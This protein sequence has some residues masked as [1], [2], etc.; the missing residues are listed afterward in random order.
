M[1]KE[2]TSKEV[3]L[4]YSENETEISKIWISLGYSASMKDAVN[5]RLRRKPLGETQRTLDD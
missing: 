4:I 2:L 5:E 3:V 1:C